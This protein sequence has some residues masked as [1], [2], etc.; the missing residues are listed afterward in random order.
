MKYITICFLVCAIALTA[1]F[2][3]KTNTTQHIHTVEQDTAQTTNG[4]PA[5]HPNISTSISP[6]SLIQS[7]LEITGQARLWYFEGSFPVALLDADGN[8]IA[9]GI[10]TAQSDWMTSEFVPFKATLS[11]NTTSTS[12]VLMFKKDNPSGDPLRD[13]TFQIP[14]RLSN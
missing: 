4:A 5:A 9:Q 12:G 13:E 6:N 2:E 11:W 7:P 3:W 8:T 1:Y 10:A 14:I